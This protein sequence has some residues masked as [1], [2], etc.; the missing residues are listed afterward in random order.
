[1]NFAEW[2]GDRDLAKLGNRLGITKS[3]VSLLKNRKRT[4]SL[5]LALR[6]KRLTG[7]VVAV[8]GW[9]KKVPRVGRKA[10]RR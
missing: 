4:P 10:S 8:D 9:K 3:M 2:A 5:A 7:G 6:I 1:M